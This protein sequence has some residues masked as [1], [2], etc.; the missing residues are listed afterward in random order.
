MTSGGN[1]SF[2]PKTGYQ[3]HRCLAENKEE[4]QAELIQPFVEEKSNGSLFRA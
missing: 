3:F 1:A 4:T 2:F